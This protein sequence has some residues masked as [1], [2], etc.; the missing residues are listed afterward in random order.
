MKD[1]K[2]NQGLWVRRATRPV[3]YIVI[4]QRFPVPCPGMGLKN[5][6]G[7]NQR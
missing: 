1:K 7:K 4:E 2:I 6:E 5:V 3:F